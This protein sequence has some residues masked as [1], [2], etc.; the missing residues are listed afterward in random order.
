MGRSS[1][2]LELYTANE[3]KMEMKKKKKWKIEK[4]KATGQLCFWSTL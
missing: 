4:Q 3:W 2:K 1:L